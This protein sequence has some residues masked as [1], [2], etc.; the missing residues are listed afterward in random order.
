MADRHKMEDVQRDLVKK[1][2][3]EIVYSPDGILP[4]SNG[5]VVDW[6]VA[7]TQQWLASKR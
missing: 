7:Q 2:G 1:T 4:A 5:R 6:I 3:V